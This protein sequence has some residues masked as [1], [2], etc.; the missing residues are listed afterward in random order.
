MVSSPGAPRVSGELDEVT[1]LRDL[2]READARDDVDAAIEA[3]RH[4]LA[5]AET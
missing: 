5:P 2:A 4:L 1:R 3:L